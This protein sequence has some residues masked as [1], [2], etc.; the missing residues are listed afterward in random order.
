MKSL[1]CVRQGRSIVLSI[2]ITMKDNCFPAPNCLHLG[3]ISP[4]GY[5]QLLRQQVYHALLDAQHRAEVGKSFWFVGHIKNKSGLD[6]GQVHLLLDKNKKIILLSTV[7]YQCQI[8]FVTRQTCH[9][10]LF[11]QKTIFAV[12]ITCN[13]LDTL[14]CMAGHGPDVAQAWHRVY[15][16][17]VGRN[18]QFC[19]L[20]KLDQSCY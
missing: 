4:S 16:V 2:S 3:S 14:R 20:V 11:Y 6:G 15:R 7:K 8:F 12:F 1:F 18:F 19:V 13:S 5:E 9:S 17:K 10:L